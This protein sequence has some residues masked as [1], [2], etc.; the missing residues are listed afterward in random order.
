[1]LKF[2]SYCLLHFSTFKMPTKYK[3][4]AKRFKVIKYMMSHT[5]F[6]FKLKA[7]LKYSQKK[8]NFAKLHYF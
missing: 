6:L 7:N 4:N 8:I 5:I 2:T 1:M 3:Y